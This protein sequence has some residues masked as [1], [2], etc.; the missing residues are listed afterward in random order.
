MEEK[1]RGRSEEEIGNRETWE[2][3]E[4]RGARK[5]KEKG[6]GGRG[7]KKQNKTGKRETRE[8]ENQAKRSKME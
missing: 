1:G 3:V 5:S 2:K 6:K 7:R 8:S 4:G